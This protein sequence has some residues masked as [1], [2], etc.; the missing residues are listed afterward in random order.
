MNENIP[1]FASWHHGTLVLFATEA[2]IKM[3]DQ[4]ALIQQLRQLIASAPHDQAPTRKT[5]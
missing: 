5:D 2:F 4:R 3:Q 1:D